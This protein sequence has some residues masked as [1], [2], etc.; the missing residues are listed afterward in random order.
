MSS[1]MILLS[2]YSLMF[3]MLSSL[4]FNVIVEVNVDLG[5][6]V[7]IL[8]AVIADVIYIDALICYTVELL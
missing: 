6:K 1:G 4:I 3:I 5:I 7:I 2:I 8:D